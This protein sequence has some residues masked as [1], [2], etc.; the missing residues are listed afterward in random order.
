MHFLKNV[1]DGAV[2]LVRQQIITNLLSLPQPPLHGIETGHFGD[3]PFTGTHW[4]TYAGEKDVNPDRD[5]VRAMRKTAEWLKKYGAT[6]DLAM[7][8]PEGGHGGFHMIPKNCDKALDVFEK[9]R[10]KE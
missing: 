10:V 7:E 6:V 4:V 3:Q 2:D 8:D 1:I 9:L 5:G